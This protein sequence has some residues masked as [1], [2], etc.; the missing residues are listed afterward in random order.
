LTVARLKPGVSFEQAR[1]EMEAIAGR[2]EQQ[3]PETNTGW[4]VA[5][6]PLLDDVVRRYQRALVI[7]LGAVGFVLLIAC[8]NLANLMLARATG[9]EKE[10]AIRSALGAGRMRIIRQLL[11]ESLV[12]A[13]IGGV[14]GVLLALWGAEMLKSSL[15]GEFAVFIPG[16]MNIGVDSQALAFTLTLSLLTGIAFGLAPALAVSKPNLNAALKEGGKLSAGVHRNR[17]RTALAIAQIAIS[18]VLLIGAGL[19]VK[20]FMRLI[21]TDPGFNPENVLTMELLLQRAK[22]REEAQRVDF[23]RQLLQRVEA[24]PGVESTGVVSHLPLGG[25]NASDSIL[26]EG[27]PEPPPGQEFDG[28]YRVCSPRYFETLGIRLLRGRVF[29]EQD[30]AGASPVVIVN[31]TLARRHWPNED[32]LGRRIRFTGDPTQNPW[33]TVVGVVR[34]VKHTLDAEVKPEYYLP[35]AQDG[36]GSMSMVVRA[37]T[38]PLALAPAIRNE[39]RAIDKDQPI[40][41]IRT[42]DQVYRLKNSGRNE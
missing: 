25:S 17:V 32:P 2:L 33:M 6:F 37:R 27:R 35:H 41:M 16:W 29:T 9:R 3:Y 30:Q 15:P 21:A 7:L 39:V 19:M 20:S 5:I 28:R 34:D 8:A 38:E 13:V 14:I 10:I 40:F 24:L 1:A 36:W 31:E 26:I 42:M 4:G 11:I 22:Y 12:L 23:F 18:L